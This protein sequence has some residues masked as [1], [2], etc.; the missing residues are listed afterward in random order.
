MVNELSPSNAPDD[1]HVTTPMTSTL[2]SGLPNPYLGPRRLA[3]SMSESLKALY[4]GQMVQ[5]RLNMHPWERADL[6]TARARKDRRSSKTV[7][8][9]AEPK[10]SVPE[11]PVQLVYV[12]FDPVFKQICDLL[13]IE[14]CHHR[15][16]V[17]ENS[18]VR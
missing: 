8:E 18:H 16:T 6:C 13:V 11:L 1:D 4:P 7:A 3:P 17:A 12:L 5:G 14:L 15:V 10:G 2:T 9:G